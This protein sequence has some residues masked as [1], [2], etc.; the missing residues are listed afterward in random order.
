[1]KIARFKMLKIISITIMGMFSIYIQREVVLI[2]IKHGISTKSIMITLVELNV[3]P[4]ILIFLFLISVKM[5]YENR[6]PIKCSIINAF[7]D[8]R[9]ISIGFVGTL[10]ISF[11]DDYVYGA[12]ILFL[13]IIFIVYVIL[14]IKHV[15]N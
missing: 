6:Q 14:K 5:I 13:V 7:R 3:I 11:R 9:F 12:Y 15:T 2:G 8:R 10:L 4:C 1:M